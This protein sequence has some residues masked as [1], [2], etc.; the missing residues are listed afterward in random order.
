[1]NDITIIGGGSSGWFT[2]AFLSYHNPDKEIVLIEAPDIQNIGVG[3]GTFPTTMHLLNSIGIKP[4]EL[5]AKSNA[6]LKIGIQYVDFASKPFWLTVQP[7]DEWQ[8]FG[9]DLVNSLAQLNK[10]PVID[11][12]INTFHAIHFIADD[13]INLLKTYAIKYGV[14]HISSKVVDSSV[15]ND[16]CSSI[17]L[18]TGEI[19]K[20]KWFVDCSG[21]LRLLI[22]QTSSKFVSYSK[23]LLVNSAVVGP[24]DY[25]HI[26]REFNVFTRITAKSSGWQFKVP[27]YKRTGNGYVYSS[28]FISSEVAEQTLTKTV[29]LTKPAKHIKM[30]LGYYDKLIVGNIVAVGLS[31][32][33]IEPLEATAIYIAERVAIGFNEVLNGLK[34]T[35]SI[36]AILSDKIH[37]IKTLILAHYAFNQRSDPFWI[38][39]REA[40][41]SS[42]EIKEFFNQLNNKSYPTEQDSL[43]VAYPYCQWNDLLRGFN[44]PH[45]YPV[46][47]SA[48]K[49]QVYLATYYLPNHYNYITSI[50]SSNAG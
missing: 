10:C 39:A 11:D 50:R 43:D 44:K 1:M 34:N 27:T 18:D 36:N 32:G 38:A 35:S 4:S 49:N 19:I 28:D 48:A 14:K 37:Y 3:E 8:Q 45:M 20:S 22:K 16:V 42:T 40:A 24:A 9:S 21:F 13:F 26:D 23:E 46:V 15:E 7:I 31:A 5:I 47:S 17:T 29:K 2:A 6:G 12:S 25:T 41:S 30:N 33:F